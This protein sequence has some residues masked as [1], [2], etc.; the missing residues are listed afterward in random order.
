MGTDVA[1]VE[2]YVLR[3]LTLD[4]E[5]PRLFVAAVDLAAPGAAL[6]NRTGQ[7]NNTRREVGTLGVGDPLFEG[8]C[9]GEVVRGNEGLID[10]D[11]IP[12]AQGA[13]EGNRIEVDAIAGADDGLVS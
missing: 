5:V 4:G 12:T 7:G 11:G 6:G 2:N 10:N 9:P 3:Q 1:E 8:G 13:R